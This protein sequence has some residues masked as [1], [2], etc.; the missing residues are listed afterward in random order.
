MKY[1]KITFNNHPILGSVS[2][3][4][5]DAQG[6]TVDTII[7]AGENGCGKSFLLSFLNTY[8][9]SM[10]ANRLGYTM[11]VEVELTDDDIRMLYENKDF[12]NVLGNKFS[13]NIVTFIHETNFRD[14]SS[15]AEFDSIAGGKWIDYA[16][17]FGVN[18]NI[19]KSVFH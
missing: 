4:F 18:P 6:K 7:I 8:N 14:D 1:R 13:G 19:Y 10:S 3:D 15:R 5:T 12:V 16:Y 17:R 9:P 11:R 2:F